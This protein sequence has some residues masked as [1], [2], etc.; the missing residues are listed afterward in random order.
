MA[1]SQTFRL[2]HASDL[3]LAQRPGHRGVSDLSSKWRKLALVLQAAAGRDARDIMSTY[4]TKQLRALLR[5]LR[6]LSRFSRGEY[7]GIIITG[8][9]AT[10]GLAADMRSARNVL[11]GSGIG[12][13]DLRMVGALPPERTVLLPGN[14]DRYAGRWLSPHSAQFEMGAHFG[15]NW[16]T[17]SP[18]HSDSRSQLNSVVL[19]EKNGV[20]LAVVTAD[21]ALISTPLNLLNAWGCGLAH[22]S[23]LSEMVAQTQAHTSAG[24]AVIWAMH[25]PPVPGV[26]WHLALTK[27]SAVGDAARSAGVEVILAGHTHIANANAQASSSKGFTGVRVVCAGTPCAAGDGERSYFELQ[28]L[29]SNGVRPYARVQTVTKMKY[30]PM[31]DRP[32]H[33]GQHGDSADFCPVLNREAVRL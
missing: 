4:S 1:E 24:I 9:L 32:M 3:H 12:G 16:C 15:S 6:G 21:L 29:V 18:I 27:D 2:A 19:P 26:P 5:S 25:F 8:D 10:T 7:D 33:N 23:V 28:V 14:H 13:L 11:D 17:H 31:N 22:A 20:H 30:T